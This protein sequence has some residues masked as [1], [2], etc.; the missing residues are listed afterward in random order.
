LLK[1]PEWQK[2]YSMQWKILGQTLF[3]RASAS[4]SKF[5]NDKKYFNTVKIFRAN[6]VFEGKCKVAQKSRMIKAIFNT[7]KHFRANSVSQGKCKLL[8]NPE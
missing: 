5:L 7:V 6:S 3:L 1:N 8:K 4:C 2:L